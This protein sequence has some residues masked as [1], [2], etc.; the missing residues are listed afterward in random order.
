[1]IVF[2]VDPDGTQRW[3]TVRSDGSEEYWINDKLHREDGSAVIFPNGTQVWYKNGKI[4]REDGPAVI[5]PNG[6]QEWYLNGDQKW[7]LNEKQ[8]EPLN[9]ITI[10]QMKFNIKDGF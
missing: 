1:M 6:T 5:H 2:T 8:T 9:K 4:H 10:N 7:Y 3:Y